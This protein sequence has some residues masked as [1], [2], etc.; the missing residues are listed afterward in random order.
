MQGQHHVVNS[1]HTL[2]CFLQSAET[3]FNEHKYIVFKW[4]G[5]K[6]TLSQN[7]LKSVWYADIAKHRGD[8]T[9]KEVEN[10]C[11]LEFGIPILRR[12]PANNWVYE[13]TLDRLP[14]DK[15]LTI[16]PKFAVT[17][18]MS[19]KELTEYLGEMQNRYPFLRSRGD[20]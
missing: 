3:L 15:R 10:E 11:K 20:V 17:S 8:M 19:V 16:M 2:K 13:R 1:E 12:D 5:G 14:Y 18:S 9:A 7:A 4:V 6:R